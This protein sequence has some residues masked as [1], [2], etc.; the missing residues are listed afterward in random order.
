[1]L[2]GNEKW[3]IDNG[4]SVSDVRVDALSE[5]TTDIYVGIDRELCAIISLGTQLT[6][7]VSSTNWYRGYA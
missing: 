6:A 3:M 7:V 5:G 1:M 4:I 2:L